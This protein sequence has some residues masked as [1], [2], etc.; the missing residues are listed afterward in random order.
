MQNLPPERP[1]DQL[2]RHETAIK[3]LEDGAEDQHEVNQQLRG[4]QDRLASELQSLREA[5]NSDRRVGTIVLQTI[6][7][8]GKWLIYLCLAVMGWGWSHWHQIDLFFHPP[9]DGKM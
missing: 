8:G 5:Y 4:A 6:R 1:I 7:V 9:A 3:L 2:R